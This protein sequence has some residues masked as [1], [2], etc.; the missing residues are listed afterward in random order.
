MGLIGHEA[1][2]HYVRVWLS[3]TDV[4]P[5]GKDSRLTLIQRVWL[6]MD[7]QRGCVL[8][9]SHYSHEPFTFFYIFFSCGDI[10]C[11]KVTK[12]TTGASFCMLLF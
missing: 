4:K 12:R 6:L 9:R 1:N 7:S 11:Q 3:E 5:N 10:L 8:V 2:V